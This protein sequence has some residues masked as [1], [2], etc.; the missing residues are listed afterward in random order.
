MTPARGEVWLFDLGMT[1]KVRPVLV[2]S[3]LYGDQDRALITVM[4]HTTSLRDSH[5]EIEVKAPFLLVFAAMLGWL[6]AVTPLISHLLRNSFANQSPM[7]PAILNK[8]L[9]RMHPG[10][11]HP[12]QKNPRPLAL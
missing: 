8:N 5:F 1:A 9:I 11:D 12:R 10:H 4:P 3:M 7:K 2:V 6:G